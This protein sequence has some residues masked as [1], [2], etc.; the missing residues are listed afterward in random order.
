MN[1][2]HSYG[3]VALQFMKIITD[4]VKKSHKLRDL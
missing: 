4:T 1:A 3:A 2:M